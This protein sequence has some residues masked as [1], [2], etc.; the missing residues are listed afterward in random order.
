[1]VERG[2]V[3]C[4]SCLAFFLVLGQT[5]MCMSGS[6]VFACFAVQTVSTPKYFSFRL[7][8]CSVF[9]VVVENKVFRIFSA[10]VKQGLS[11]ALLHEKRG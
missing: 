9:C 3:D 4:L 2:N 6:I 7:N 1:M 5:W 11:Y 8:L 10:L